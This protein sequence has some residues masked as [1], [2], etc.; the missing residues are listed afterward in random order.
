MT[1]YNDIGYSGQ[2]LSNKEYRIKVRLG[3]NIQNATGSSVCGELL[4]VTGDNGG[5]L[6]TGKLYCATETSTE[7]SSS[8]FHVADLT[9][10]VT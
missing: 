6:T 10:Q 2:R 3:D 4:L 9:T 1:T 7:S 5:G 8:I